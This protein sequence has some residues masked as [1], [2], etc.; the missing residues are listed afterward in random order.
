M[1][2]YALYKCPICHA[3]FITLDDKFKHMKQFHKDTCTKGMNIYKDFR[4][5]VLWEFEQVY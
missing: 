5:S 3:E 2:E 1:T 4:Q